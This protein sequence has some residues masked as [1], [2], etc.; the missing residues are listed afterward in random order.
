MLLHS[1]EEIARWR[2]AKK[3]LRVPAKRT[4]AD[5]WM[6]VRSYPGNKS[7]LEI[8]L[9]GKH[10]RK[11]SPH[12]QDD[13]EWRWRSVRFPAGAWRFG[14]NE[15]VLRCQSRAMNGWMLGIENGHRNPA[16]F[17]STDRGQ[18]WR[19]E[20]M[21]AHG[22]L[23]GEYLIRIALPEHPRKTSP[24]PIVYEDVKHPR[25]RELR[26][27]VSTRIRNIRDPW[28]Q[29][30]ALR[31]WI[32][33]AWTYEAFGKSYAPLDPWTVLAWKSANWG[34]GRENPIAMCVH[35]GMVFASLAAALGHTSRGVAITEN[36][37]GPD[38]HFMTEIFDCDLGKWVAHDANFDLHYEN[39]EPMSIIDLAERSRAGKS[40]AAMIR[41]GSGFTSDCPRLNGL[42]KSKLATGKSF[43]S[44]AV[45]RL[46][47][48]ISDPAA[49]PPNH[50]SVVYCETDFVWYV[51][52]GTVKNLAMFPHR[53][54]DR[55]YFSKP[56]RPR[57]GA[58]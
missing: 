7:P 34:H 39:G 35:Y 53:T 46:N 33:K 22:A 17:L 51:P 43:T 8:I 38:G 29:I 37:N 3:L 9:N 10:T 28:R 54:S 4:A 27:L 15:I 52:N 14:V 19:N 30:L 13:G 2:W 23:R 5:V 25:M 26:D 55:E 20:K 24:P 41:R 21:G 47:N 18:T 45:W 48:V 36:I 42:L 56:P 58:R 16:S 6:C 1:N 40:L 12:P 49:A 31:N 32:A 44:V 50:G 11:L 57:G